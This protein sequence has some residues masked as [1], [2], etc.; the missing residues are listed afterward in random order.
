MSS[1]HAKKCKKI[2][3]IDDNLFI[4]NL[5]KN[6]LRSPNSIISTSLTGEEGYEL[7]C[8]QHPDIILLDRRLGDISGAKILKRIKSNPELRDIPVAMI[9]SDDNDTDILQSLGMGAADYIVKPF[10]AQTVIS[11]VKRLIQNKSSKQTD[12]YYV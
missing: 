1:T 11:K 9:S 2:L 6:I 4:L 7:A 8:I 5:V 12:Y 10:N 3:I